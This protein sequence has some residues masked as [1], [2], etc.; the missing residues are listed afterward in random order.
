MSIFQIVIK[1][2][3]LFCA[4]FLHKY[5]GKMKV[6]DGFLVM[7]PGKILGYRKWW[8]REM[9]TRYELKWGLLP[10]VHDGETINRQT[11]HRPV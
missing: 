3:S 6:E 10:A 9:S 7:T 5:E 4:S 11:W 2:L 1:S 8:L